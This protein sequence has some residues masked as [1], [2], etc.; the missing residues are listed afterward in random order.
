MVPLA[1]AAFCIEVWKPPAITLACGAPPISRTYS[2]EIRP[3][4]SGSVAPASITAR[5]SSVTCFAISTAAAGN[6]S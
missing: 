3:T 2:I 1:Y 5:P 6:A 4:P